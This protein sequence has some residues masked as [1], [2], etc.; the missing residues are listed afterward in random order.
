MSANNSAAIVDSYKAIRTRLLAAL[1][2]GSH[3]HAVVISSPSAKDGKTTT[4]INTAIAFSQLG[5]RVLLIDADM[6]QGAISKRLHLSS[7]FGLSDLLEGACALDQAI[8]SA[9][10]SLDVIPAGKIASDP[11]KLL[12]S[13]EYE[14]LISGVK[15]AYDYIFIDSPSICEYNDTLYTSKNTDGIVLVLREGVSAYKKIDA[16]FEYLK[17]SNITVLGTVINA[18]KK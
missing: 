18:A 8:V 9:G 5:K 14:N 12:S 17:G 3:S 11:E 6:R 13:E 7:L 2:E 16:A 4:A 10:N 1:G 15:F